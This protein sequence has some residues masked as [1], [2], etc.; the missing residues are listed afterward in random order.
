MTRNSGRRSNVSIYI[1]EIH[2]HGFL[3]LGVWVSRILR[4]ILCLSMSGSRHLAIDLRHWPQTWRR[5]RIQD[6]FR[7]FGSNG[8][9]FGL[10]MQVLERILLIHLLRCFERR[11]L[12][13]KMDRIA[14]VLD[15]PL[16]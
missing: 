2:T 6:R 4:G 5:A 14:F 15:G 10:V 11:R 16:A 13:Q 7:D 12:L 3:L 1:M 9:A 8:E